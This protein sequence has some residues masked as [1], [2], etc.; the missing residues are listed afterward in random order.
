MNNPV[1][2]WELRFFNDATPNL[3]QGATQRICFLANG[4][5]YST[6]FPNWGGSWF[7]KGDNAAGNGNRVR[8]FGN[9]AG[10]VGNDSA[11]LDYV[12]NRLMTGSWT[13]WRDV[14][15]SGFRFWGRARLR[16]I[17][18]KCP[19]PAKVDGADKKTLRKVRNLSPAENEV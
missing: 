16:W 6:T 14:G 7:Q 8:V 15:S 19:K 5:W 13:E 2:H 1:G 9:Y 18:K 12:S 3:S 11:E 17:G 4:T 10:G